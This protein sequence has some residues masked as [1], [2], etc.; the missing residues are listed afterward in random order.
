MLSEAVSET[1]FE[2][3]AKKSYHREHGEKINFKN[4]VPSVVNLLTKQF[5]HLVTKS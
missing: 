4:S 5:F 1:I 3:G 2:E